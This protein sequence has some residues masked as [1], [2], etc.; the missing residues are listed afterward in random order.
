MMRCLSPLSP[1]V[2]SVLLVLLQGSECW[3]FSPPNAKLATTSSF[4]NLRVEVRVA[5]L[6]RDLPKIKECRS[7]AFPLADDENIKLWSSQRAFVEAKSAVKGTSICLIAQ[8][9]FPPFRVLGT[10]DVSCTPRS[11]REGSFWIQNVFVLPEARGQGLAQQL[12]QE[13]ETLVRSS[14]SESDSSIISLTVDTSNTPAVS[15]YRKLDYEFK[16]INGALFSL[17]R[18][19]G[20]TLRANM[21]KEIISLKSYELEQPNDVVVQ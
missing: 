11:I 1:V 15:V 6:P 10:A 18:T 2:I 5:N 7:A 21:V 19:T 16:G 13:V 9:R 4:S 8:E 17:S 20:A 14:L 12:V 3:S